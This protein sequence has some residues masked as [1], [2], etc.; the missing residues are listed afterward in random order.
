MQIKTL[1]VALFAGIAM[2]MPTDPPKNGG[3]GGSTPPTTPPTT[4]PGGGSGDYDACEG[5]GLLYSSAQCCATD[6]LGVADLDCAVPASPTFAPR[7]ANVLAAVC[8]LS[9][10]KLSFARPQSEPKLAAHLRQDIIPLLDS[11]PRDFNVFLPTQL[12][13]SFVGWRFLS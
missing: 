6:V 12:K 10:A 8:S 1:I 13:G 7:W 4:P 3:G 2:A 5:N 11:S 9:P